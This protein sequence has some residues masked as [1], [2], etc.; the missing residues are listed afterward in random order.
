MFTSAL[1]ENTN[2]ITLFRKMNKAQENAC[3]FARS[4][5]KYSLAVNPETDNSGK[6]RPSQPL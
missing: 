2:T 4:V 6:R 3:K 1:C 5:H